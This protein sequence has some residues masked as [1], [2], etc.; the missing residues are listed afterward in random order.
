MNPAAE[1]VVVDEARAEDLASVLQLYSENEDQL[2]DVLDLAAALTIW[3]RFD[4]YPDY[5][6]YVARTNS[7]IVG[8]FALLIMDNLA[9]RGA[10]S[11]V[12]EDV[13]V[14][15]KWRRRGIGRLMMHFALARCRQSGCYKLTLSSNLNRASAHL[16]YEAVGFARHGYSFIATLDHGENSPHDDE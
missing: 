12:V 9:H 3:L 6:L 2:T 10:K 4:L 8:T 16:F 13:I 7:E 5:K 1:T 11:G 15:K 14:A